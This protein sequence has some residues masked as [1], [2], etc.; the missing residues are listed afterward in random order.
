[1]VKSCYKLCTWNAALEIPISLRFRIFYETDP[2]LTAFVPQTIHY[3][4]TIM[5]SPKSEGSWTI[6]EDHDDD[7]DAA[8][9][10]VAL[11]P[12]RELAFSASASPH[13]PQPHFYSS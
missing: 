2:V 6:L 10:G 13:S 4:G 5:S 11:T 3:T 8:A 7:D 12:S 1:M 9:F